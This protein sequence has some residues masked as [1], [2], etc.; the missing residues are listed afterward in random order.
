MSFLKEFAVTANLSAQKIS[1]KVF[2]KDQSVSV[3]AQTNSL[4]TDLSLCVSIQS[5][6]FYFFPSN[7]D[8]IFDF[9]IFFYLMFE[10]RTD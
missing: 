3:C 5:Q 2:R 4:L 10:L 7:Q 8:S 1:V 6:I 9:L